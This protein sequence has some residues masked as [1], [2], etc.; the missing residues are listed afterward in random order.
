MKEMGPGVV[1]KR[2]PMMM[3]ENPHMMMKIDCTMTRSPSM[4][5]KLVTERLA[6]SAPI[7]KLEKDEA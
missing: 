3:P 4:M 6:K 5:M 2:R 7:S 1:L